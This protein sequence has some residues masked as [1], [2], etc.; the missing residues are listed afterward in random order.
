M[1]SEQLQEWLI[2]M[3]GLKP[4]E[5]RNLEAISHNSARFL[6]ENSPTTDILIDYM[7][8]NYADQSLSEPIF[9]Q[10]LVAYYRGGKCL[11]RR[12]N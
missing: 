5:M 1:N 6:R 11:L 8:R 4:D 12:I 9:A 10:I 3:N 2:E 7:A